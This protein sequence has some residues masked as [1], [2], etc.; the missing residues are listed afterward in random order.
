[1]LENEANF[2]FIKKVALFEQILDFPKRI[3]QILSDP[4]H[5]V[6]FNEAHSQITVASIFRNTQNPKQIILVSSYYK[7][8]H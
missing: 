1:M 6:N 3:N 5:R 2:H 8:I 4:F 7:I